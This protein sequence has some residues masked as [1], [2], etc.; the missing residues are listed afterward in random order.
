MDW[1]L[2]LAE[3]LSLVSVDCTRYSLSSTVNIICST[4]LLLHERVI[5]EQ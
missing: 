4:V 1:G 2:G 3:S 5:S